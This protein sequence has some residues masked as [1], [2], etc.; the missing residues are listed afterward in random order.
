MASPSPVPFEPFVHPPVE[1]EML[2]AL[3]AQLFDGSGVFS[4]ERVVLRLERRI[5][6]ARPAARVGFESPE[7]SRNALASLDC[8]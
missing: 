7:D 6:P 2:A 4:G 1:L 3:L 8:C 5:C